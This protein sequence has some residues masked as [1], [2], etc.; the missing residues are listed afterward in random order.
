[1]DTRFFVKNG[2]ELTQTEIQELVEIDNKIPEKYDP[3]KM[4]MISRRALALGILIIIE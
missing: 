2:K 3:F 1:M 4:E